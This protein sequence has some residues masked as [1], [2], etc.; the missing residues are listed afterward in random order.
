MNDTVL[1]LDLPWYLLR[2]NGLVY[3]VV[4]KSTDCIEAS[5]TCLPQMLSSAKAFNGVLTEYAERG[6][7]SEEFLALGK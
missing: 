3:E 7:F 2:F 6:E 5:G 1:I 4:N